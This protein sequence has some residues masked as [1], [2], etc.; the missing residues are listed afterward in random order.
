M[1]IWIIFNLLELTDL[2]QLFPAYKVSLTLNS[3]LW[4]L[5]QCTSKQIKHFPI[6]L[7]SIIVVLPPPRLLELREILFFIF[8]FYYST[9]TNIPELSD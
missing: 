5:L 7:S 9:S 6:L 2:L 4:L 3:R 8:F 1:H